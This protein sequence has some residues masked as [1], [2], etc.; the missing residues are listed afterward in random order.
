[1]LPILSKALL[2]D[3]ARLLPPYLEGCGGEL[4]DDVEPVN[5]LPQVH[6]QGLGGAPR[7]LLELLLGL[8]LVKHG[9]HLGQQ[10]LTDLVNN[11]LTGQATCRGVTVVWAV[12]LKLR[13]DKF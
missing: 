7:Q 1:M 4:G 11:L 3:V 13:V 9:G 2:P 10:V 5:L 6:S 12:L 8:L